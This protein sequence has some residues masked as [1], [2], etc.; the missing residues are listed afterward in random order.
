[1]ND[2]DPDNIYVAQSL[3]ITGN[4]LPAHGTILI[5]GNTFDYTPD[6]NFAGS[7][8]F[9]YVISDQ[10]GAVS[11]TG[12]ITITVTTPNNAPTLSD[13]GFLMMEDGVLSSSIVG[14]DIDGNTLSYSASV[15]PIYGNLTLQSNGNFVYTPDANFSGNDTFQVIATDG[16]LSSSAGLITIDVT[17]VNDLPIA[18]NDNYSLPQDTSFFVPVLSNDTDVDSKSLS[19]SGV[20]MPS[21]GVLTPSGTG[22][23]YTP[24]TSYS[25]SDSFTYTVTDD[26]G[27]SSLSAIVTLSITS[28]NTP[29]V[30][31]D[32]NL[33]LSED[34]TFTHVLAASDPEAS[35]LTYIIDT[36]PTSGILTISSTGN[37]Q[38][39]P[40]A[41]FFG[42]DSFSYHVSDGILTSPIANITLNITPLNDAPIALS[43]TYV[44]L[45]NILAQSGNILTGTLHG[46]DIDGDTLTYILKNTTLHGSLTLSATGYIIYNSALGFSGV[47]HF[48]FA[49]SDGI[50]ES[51]ITPVD[52]NVS[53]NTYVP[54][55]DTSSGTT[56]S[57]TTNSGT[58]S[59]GTTNSGTTNSGT[60][61]TG[62]VSTGGIASNLPSASSVG[63]GG[64]SSLGPSPS[65]STAIGNEEQKK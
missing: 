48:D 22:F 28:T 50:L 47:E 36:P 4:S 58:T 14:D 11:N 53:P 21:H 39:A 34:S 61:Y 45:G 1:M 30:A 40:V 56:N 42:T 52:I 31:P 3:T 27:A 44:V 12:T 25:G 62:T 9:T 20:S 29:P 59:S 41:N 23:L 65:L 19:V 16:S 64:S 17:P 38:Y 60:I 55:V 46:T 10:D 33:T 6:A 24:D 54:P 51:A 5:T 63:P 26:L 49:V 15:L 2:T 57:G 7:D 37:L 35:T 8:S 43:G 18:L 32:E 13:S